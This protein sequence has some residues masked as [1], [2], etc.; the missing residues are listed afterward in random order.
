[1]S[2]IYG[3]LRTSGP[4][5]VDGVVALFGRSMQ[6]LEAGVGFSRDVDATLGQRTGWRSRQEPALARNRRDASPIHPA[7]PSE[8]SRPT[9]LRTVENFRYSARK[10]LRRPLQL[11]PHLPSRIR[12]I[13]DSVE[14]VSESPDALRDWE[15]A[16]ADD[17]QGT[18]QVDP[19]VLMRYRRSL[20]GPAAGG[21]IPCELCDPLSDAEE[22][23]CF[24]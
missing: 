2:E 21:H 16:G 10:R 5:G 3:H 24:M 17:V 8:R 23:K 11:Q 22:I 14:F 9:P 20:K 1:M 12:S 15:F 4:G 18:V 6:E 13:P 7:L 19:V